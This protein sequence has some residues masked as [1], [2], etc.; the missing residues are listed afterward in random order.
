MRAGLLFISPVVPHP[1]GDGRRIRA[2]HMLRAL[3][4]D[5]EVHLIVTGSVRAADL[6]AADLPVAQRL[7]VPSGFVRASERLLRRAAR[8]AVPSFSAQL[9]ERPPEWV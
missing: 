7:A 8:R 6:A 4:A 3:A 5:R 9:M 2:W 1:T